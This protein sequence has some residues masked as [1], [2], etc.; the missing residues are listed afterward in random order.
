MKLT[1]LN[2]FSRQPKTLHA[3]RHPHQNRHLLITRYILILFIS[4]ATLAGAGCSDK[5]AI[6]QKSVARHIKQSKAYLSQG[7]FRAANIEARNAIQKSPDNIDGHIALGTILNELGRYKK[8]IELLEQLPDDAYKNN[9]FLYTLLNAYMGRGKYLSAADLLDTHEILMRQRPIDYSLALA[10]LNEAQDKLSAAEDIYYQLLKKSPDNVEVLLGL[11]RIKYQQGDLYNTENLISQVQVIAPLNSDIDFIKAKIS[12]DKKHYSEAE[13]LLT[14]AISNLPNADVMTPRKSAFLQLLAEILTIEGKTTEAIIYTQKIA[15]AF[16]GAEIAQGD[17]RDASAFFEKGEFQQA[18][19]LLEK[20]VAE[21]PNFEDASV[22]LGIIK[23]RSGDMNRAS[24]YFNQHIDAEI[25]NPAVTKLAAIASLRN[26][27]PERVLAMLG[28]YRHTH[29]DP[30]ILILFGQAALATQQTAK[31]ESALKRAIRLDDSIAEAYL[32][33]ADLYNSELPPNSD[34]A[35]AILQEGYHKNIDDF[36]LAAGVAQQ[37]FFANKINEAKAFI[38]LLLNTENNEAAALQLAGDFFYS[39][40]KLT[41]ASDYYHQA[42]AVN[43]LDYDSAMKLALIARDTLPYTEQLAALRAASLIKIDKIQ[44]IATMLA[45]AKT[46]AEIK[47]AEQVINALASEN[48]PSNGFAVLGR[49]YAERGQLE[50]ARAYQEKLMNN[51]PETALTKSVALA[52]H[53]EDAKQNISKGNIN[54]ARKSAM[55]GLMLAPRSPLLLVLLTEMEIQSEQYLE[56]QKLVHQI[57]MSNSVMGE[58]LQ[59]DLYRAQNNFIAAI[60][61]YQALW[62]KNPTN[63]IASK[64]YFLLNNGNN[65]NAQSFLSEWLN[66]FPNSTDALSSQANEYLIAEDYQKAVVILEQIKQQQP[67]SAINL[68]NLAW[69]YQQLSHPAALATAKRAYELA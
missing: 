67:T 58:E 34:Q 45:G 14:E 33:L 57:T 49:F 56:A 55:D 21:Y 20:L 59:G 31:A 47:Q 22:L 9:A 3:L 2:I 48:N 41:Q 50:K 63:E 62:Q 13:T 29:D 64:I 19:I 8:N 26:H 68:N 30:Q 53:Y 51:S 36:K 10:A 25:T 35:L 32:I 23:Y 17:Y 7:Q 46:A 4:L 61:T 1:N 28:Q 66:R 54:A 6:D 18:E 60:E 42:L 11:I 38:D 5:G 65:K 44:P 39:Q 37:L 43:P 15:E 40:Q 24:H 12:V 16:P 27:Q 52:I 69:C